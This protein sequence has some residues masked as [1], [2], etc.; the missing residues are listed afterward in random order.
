MGHFPDLWHRLV[1]GRALDCKNFCLK[2]DS[3]RW[4]TWIY[5][6]QNILNASGSSIT[7]PI[8]LCITSLGMQLVF[9]TPS[10][11]F[12]HDIWCLDQKK[13]CMS[14]F[15]EAHLFCALTSPLRCFMQISI[16]LPL[17]N[18]SLLRCPNVRDAVGALL[19]CLLLF[20][21]ECV[22]QPTPTLWCVAPTCFL[23]L[24]VFLIA[25]VTWTLCLSQTRK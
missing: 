23:Y 24:C 12:R 2:K 13:N 15:N 20:S 10:C 6:I 16:F 3:R 1:L 21:N 17:P 11:V 7:M 25:P 8:E 18:V 22:Q 14:L 9:A 5:G 19:Q 4:G